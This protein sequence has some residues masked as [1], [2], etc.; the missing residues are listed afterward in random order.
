MS[1][2]AQYI[3]ILFEKIDWWGLMPEQKYSRV[4]YSG[5]EHEM[6]DWVIK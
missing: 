5:D 2:S 4:A 3:L 6:G 1:L